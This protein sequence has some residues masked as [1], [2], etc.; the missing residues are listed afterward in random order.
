MVYI[1]YF[2][3]INNDTIIVRAR[4]TK[5]EICRSFGYFSIQSLFS[6]NLSKTQDNNF[7]KSSKSELLS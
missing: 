1:W 6:N 2:L 4:L 3:F 7:N 5:N